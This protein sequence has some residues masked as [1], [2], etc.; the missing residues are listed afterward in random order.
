MN[1]LT[2]PLT[3]VIL[4][5]CILFLAPDNSRAVVYE[6]DSGDI[7]DD[8]LV[9]RN[10]VGS[11]EIDQEDGHAVVTATGTNAN[12]GLAS[13][14]SFD[15]NTDGIHVSFVITE[16][17]GAPNAN[18]FLVGVVDDNSVFHRT[19]NN[20]GIAMFGQEPRTFSSDG[21]SL[22]AGDRNG[23][24]ESDFIL[25][26]GDAVDMESFQDGFTVT[27]SADPSGW[28]YKIEGLQDFDFE[29]KTFENSGTWADAGTTF[30][31]I[32]G[33]DNEWHVVT[34]NQSPGEKITRFDRI[35]LGE[36]GAPQDSDG[37]GIPDSWEEA[38][39]LDPEIDD[40]ALDPDNDGLS[41][42]EEFT[43]RTDP[44]K[45]DTDGDGLKDGDEENTHETDPKNVD[46]DGD[47]LQDGAELTTF[48]TDPAK[49]D[50]DGD[51]VGDGAEALFG[52]DPVNG[53]VGAGTFLVRNV[54]SDETMLTSMDIFQEVLDDPG[55]ILDEKTESFG[56]INYRDNAQGKFAEGDRAFPVLGDFETGGDDFGI[57][58][59]GSFFVKEAGLRTFGV[60]SDDGNLLLID[61]EIVVDDS[62]THGSRDAFGAV[63]LI[64]GQ[65]TLELFYFE[66]G[67]GAHVEVF[68]NAELGEV[69][70]FRDGTFLLLPAFGTAVIDGDGDGLRDLWEIQFFGNTDQ[71]ADADPDGDGLTNLQ[72]QEAGTSPDKKDTDGD[73]LEDNAELSGDPASNPTKADTDGDGIG[74]AEEIANGTNPTRVDSDGDGLSDKWE[75]DNATNPNDPGSPA[76]V[77]L[78]DLG[79]P[80]EVWN[81][82]MALPT[83]NGFD[84]GLD[85]ADATFLV[86]IDFE[87]KQDPEREVIF[88]TGAGT[89]G[90]SLVYEEGN[91][92]V[93]R[94][95]GSGGFSLAVA[96]GRR[97]RYPDCSRRSRSHVELRSGKCRRNPDDHPLAEQVSRRGRVHGSRR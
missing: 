28:S 9:Q 50:T 5:A 54:Q 45:D 23:S 76:G 74:D 65:H 73:G 58:V 3:S 20:F 90:F 37:D 91:K 30:D 88:E 44:Q 8:W 82:V 53:E 59:T 48:S 61:G 6:F 16:V 94:A 93:L 29:D 13:I 57:H 43:L 67:G 34:A 92:L 80:T 38:N 63:E 17:V 85:T 72:E 81:E 15:P 86:C 25:D 19:A 66:R 18:G 96:E 77:T 1:A 11:V 62:G 7:N 64:E 31:E 49:V 14:A 47:G 79:E 40:A 10:A 51:G 78:K 41:N 89:V 68:V 55:Q 46:T 95:A 71:T 56:F 87:P 12:G 32:F 52:G 36:E 27:I 39:D 26:E 69:D 75:A 22:I 2:N 60:N 33:G 21:F 84:G 4:A 70:N 97:A 35:V 42:L 83:F 24:S